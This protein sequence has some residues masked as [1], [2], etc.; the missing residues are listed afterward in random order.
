MRANSHNFGSSQRRRKLKLQNG[1]KSKFTRIR[2]RKHY[3]VQQCR[4]SETQRVTDPHLSGLQQN[5]KGPDA[6]DRLRPS[7]LQGVCFCV[8]EWKVR[9]VHID[10]A[11]FPD[12]G[13]RSLCLIRIEPH[14]FCGKMEIFYRNDEHHDSYTLK[15]TRLHHFTQSFIVCNLGLANE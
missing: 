14:P 2:Y 7:L 4:S 6:S 1:H 10:V 5:F 13:L 9:F 8:Y 11:L 15:P 3:R 12:S